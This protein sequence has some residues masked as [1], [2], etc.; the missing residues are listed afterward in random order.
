VALTHTSPPR[1]GLFTA[2]YRPENSKQLDPGEITWFHEQEAWFNQNLATP[3][4]LSRSKR[5]GA[6]KAALLWLKDTATQHVRR[7]HALAALLRQRDVPVEILVS[8]TPGYV[9]YEDPYQVA[10]EPFAL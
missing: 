9:V 1:I 8:E 7:M 2:L 5:T 4:H 3:T 6:N 10:A